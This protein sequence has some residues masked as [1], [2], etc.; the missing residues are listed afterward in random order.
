MTNAEVIAQ[1]ER[2]NSQQ[3]KVYFPRV[4]KAIQSKQKEV[5]AVLKSSGIEAAKQHL[6]NSIGNEKLTKVIEELYKKVGLAHAR[7][8]YSRMLSDTGKKS[9]SF[10]IETKGFGFNQVWTN[11]ILGYL[12]KFLLEKITYHV[13]VT[14][15]DSLLAI[16]SV[17]TTEGWSIDQTIDKIENWPG[18]RYQAARVVR[19]EVNRAANVG[20]RANSETFAYEQRKEWVDAGDNRVRGKKPKDHANHAKLGGTIIDADDLF[21]DSINGDRLEFPGDINASA[22]STVFC[23]CL[24]I[25]T[26]K[27]DKEGN[28][29]PKRRSTAVI[30]PRQLP[31]RQTISI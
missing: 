29:I 4:R 20:A 19:T 7:L 3:E 6:H 11:Y 21:H 24:V 5:V 15:R 8:N 10:P 30:F 16:L 18:E 22:A 26:A 28:L 31:Q 1:Y 13:A 2:V 23:R 17:A 9:Y 27:R 12:R 25:Y 14:T